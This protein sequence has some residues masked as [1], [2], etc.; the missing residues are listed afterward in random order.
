MPDVDVV[1]PRVALWAGAL[2][3]PVKALADVE[4]GADGLIVV[5]ALGIDVQ[6]ALSRALAGAAE[7]A[8]R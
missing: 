5:E 8:S 1:G 7:R 4:G 2:A 3:D 6:D